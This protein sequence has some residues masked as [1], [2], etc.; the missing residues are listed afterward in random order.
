[1]N[2]VQ[3]FTL[4]D[5]RQR[6]WPDLVRGFGDFL[7]KHDA[8]SQ[9]ALSFFQLATSK[10]L[11]MDIRGQHGST[12]ADSFGLNFLCWSDR[13]APVIVGMAIRQGNGVV[14]LIVVDRMGDEPTTTVEYFTPPG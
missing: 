2:A 4:E 12:G 9:A 14:V 8:M 11:R 5:L 10:G 7:F 13:L 3:E 1:M 6:L